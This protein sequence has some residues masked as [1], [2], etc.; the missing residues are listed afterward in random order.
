MLIFFL[1]QITYPNNLTKYQPNMRYF[2]H[3]DNSFR[4]QNLIRTNLEFL[5]SEFDEEN[6]NNIN[7]VTFFYG[8]THRKINS[9][10]SNMNVRHQRRHSND[11]DNCLNF[12]DC[13]I[14]FHNFVEYNNGIQSIIDTCLENNIPLVVFSDHVKKGFLSNATGELSIT[15]EFPE[16][17]KLKSSIT[18]QEF[19]FVPYRFVL[20]TSFKEVVH[21]TRENYKEL[22]DIKRERAIKLYNLSLKNS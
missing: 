2:V 3:C 8:Y 18:V 1:R 22:S 17:K 19:N 11:I 6:P 14:L 13:V 20:H 15:R 16:V 12:T 9:A 21:L 10:L 7:T 4:K 5:N